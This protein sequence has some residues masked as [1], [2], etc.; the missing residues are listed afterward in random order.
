VLV[1]WLAIVTLLA[2]WLVSAFVSSLTV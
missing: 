1:I 2:W